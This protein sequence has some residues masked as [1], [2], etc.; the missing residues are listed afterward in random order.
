MLAFLKKHQLKI[1]FF[2]VAILILTAAFVLPELNHSAESPTVS[3]AVSDESSVVSVEES[4][5]SLSESKTVTVVSLSE[6]KEESTQSSS[7]ISE[8]SEVSKK[9]SSVSELSQNSTSSGTN[10]A[11]KHEEK[12]SKPQ[13][14]VS[15]AE[16]HMVEVTSVPSE[17]S[18]S[19]ESSQVSKTESSKVTSTAQ[20]KVPSTVST[21]SSEPSVQPQKTASVAISCASVLNHADKKKPN[22]KGTVPQNGVILSTQTVEIIEGETVLDF[23]KRVCRANRIPFE[24]SGGYVEGID[25]L[26]EFDYGNLSG[27]MYSVNGEFLNYGSNEVKLKPNDTVKWLY[28]CDLGKDIGNPYE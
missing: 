8:V 25:N 22:A 16:S 6:S 10:S 28:T 3:S 12:S 9:T 20:S 26:Y 19:Q 15:V 11:V 21:V 5:S 24:F 4:C 27:W 7:K 1:I 23:T 17:S 14:E 2:L 18:V 13:R